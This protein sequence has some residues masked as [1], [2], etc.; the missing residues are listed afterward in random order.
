MNL[1]ECIEIQGEGVEERLRELGLPLDS[2]MD[3]V[4]TVGL[5]HALAV[6]NHPP[7][8][9]GSTAYG[10]STKVLRDRLM[11][12]GWT[13]FNF[14]GSDLTRSPDGSIVIRTRG[15]NSRVGLPGIPGKPAGP[16]HPIGK[17]TAEM[18]NDPRVLI[19]GQLDL[20]RDEDEPVGD[21]P[22]DVKTYWLLTYVDGAS[23]RSEL[24]YALGVKKGKIVDWVERILLP[25]IHLGDEPEVATEDD[26]DTEAE[27]V[28]T[29]KS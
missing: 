13:R 18:V 20:F 19:D 21:A 8:Y 6:G 17:A 5:M 16:K 24:S 2:A 26:Q 9:G 14:Q 27:I 1:A 23:L 12:L 7:W 10:E 15:G 29:E 25:E 4:R 3:A 22:P 11:P 28:V